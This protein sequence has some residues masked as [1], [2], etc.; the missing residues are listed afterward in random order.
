MLEIQPILAAPLLDSTLPKDI[1]RLSSQWFSAEATEEGVLGDL[2][3][4]A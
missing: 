4:E 3:S 1:F 2:L